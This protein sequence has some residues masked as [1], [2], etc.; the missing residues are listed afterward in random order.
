MTASIRLQRRLE[1]IDTDASGHWHNTVVIRWL[2]WAEGVLLDRLGMLQ[3]LYGHLPRVRIE[4]EFRRPLHYNDLADI[5]LE[6]AEV[7]RSSV[8]YACRVLHEGELCA[9]L[10]VV[11]VLRGADGRAASFRDDL[12]ELLLS[13]GEQ[14]A[15]Q[16]A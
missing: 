2:E 10:R 9:E 14:E 11:C 16:V 5:E 13:A 15:L 6:V 12:R 1:W 7:G 3:E 4:A 8:T